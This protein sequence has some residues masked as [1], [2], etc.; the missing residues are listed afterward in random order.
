M[1]RGEGGIVLNTLYK[2]RIL[3]LLVVVV[4]AAKILV[5]G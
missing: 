5:V 1:R 3:V 2:D 4:R